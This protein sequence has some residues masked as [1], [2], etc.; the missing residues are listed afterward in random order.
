MTWNLHVYSNKP[1]QAGGLLQGGKEVGEGR[2]EKA[3][4]LGQVIDSKVIMW[5]VFHGWVRCA[6]PVITEISVN[7][8]SWSQ[9][10]NYV[11]SGY[12]WQD[13]MLYST[14]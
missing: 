12:T 3:E 13:D 7:I 4:T 5:C 2:G 9:K 14:T 11:E 6:S 8:L 1:P 10:F